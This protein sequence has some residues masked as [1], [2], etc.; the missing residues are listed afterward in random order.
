VIS[1]DYA[2]FGETS[3]E[4]KER[5]DKEKSGESVNRGEMP[6][7]AVKDRMSKKLGHL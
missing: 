5:K 4:R 2:Y 3:N 1:I 7:I 6:F